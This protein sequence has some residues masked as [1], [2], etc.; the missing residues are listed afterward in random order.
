METQ[1]LLRTNLTLQ[2]RLKDSEAAFLLEQDKAD[3]AAREA[4]TAKAAWQCRICLSAEVDVTLVPCGHVLCR[5]C[6]SAVSKCP[7]CRLQVSKTLRIFRP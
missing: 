2:E 7:F 6:S 4:D 1:T 3:T 5:R